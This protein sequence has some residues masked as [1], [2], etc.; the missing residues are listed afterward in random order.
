M[1]YDIHVH[2]AQLDRHG[3][4]EGSFMDG[5]SWQVRMLLRQLGLRRAD[6]RHRDACE[7]AQRS[8]RDWIR[9]HRDAFLS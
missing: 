4:T 9:E 7:E 3:A 6:L 1:I 5:A 2:A 8:L